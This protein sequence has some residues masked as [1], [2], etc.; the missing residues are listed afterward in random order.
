[1]TNSL[2]SSL[3]R[4]SFLRVRPSSFAGNERSRIV[5][6]TSQDCSWGSGE[7][8][9]GDVACPS[10]K[11]TIVI[12]VERLNGKALEEADRWNPVAN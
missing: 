6:P 1:M 7:K 3:L 9:P 2:E 4:S 12:N 5:D 10:K 8:N 11:S